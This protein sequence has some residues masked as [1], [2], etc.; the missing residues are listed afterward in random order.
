MMLPHENIWVLAAMQEEVRGQLMGNIS[1]DDQIALECKMVTKGVE[2]YYKSF[3]S[4][5][6]G[7]RCSN[8]VAGKALMS[9]VMTPL[10]ESI[11]KWLGEFSPEADMI[12]DLDAGRVAFM[13]IGK[14]VDNIAK[15]AKVLATAKSI[16]DEI[17]LELRLQYWLQAEK[18]VAT[19]IIKR[20]NRK[21][22]ARHKKNGLV[23]KMNK[24]GIKNVEWNAEEKMRL[25]L[26]LIDHVISS[27]GIIKLHLQSIGGGTCKTAYVIIPAEGTMEWI[28]GF[29]K[30][31]ETSRP[32]TTPFLIPPKD[33]TG[34]VGGGFH[35]GSQQRLP[36]LKN[37]P[38]DL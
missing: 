10:I 21:A 37:Y 27:T 9:S 16:A 34:I 32:R 11:D 14:V 20:A 30:H 2:R 3:D 29:N 35:N 6:E 26:R 7:G 33:W 19:S 17:Q 4:A 31:R 23:Y 8:S 25:G 12:S 1:L 22:T 28:D 38:S 18:K 24:D 15:R 36:L 5:L 13:T